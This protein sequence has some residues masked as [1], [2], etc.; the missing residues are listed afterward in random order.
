MPFVF[1]ATIADNLRFA[2]PDAT[3]DQLRAALAAVQ[4]TEFV[5]ELPDGVDAVIGE[6][7]VSLSGG[8]RQ[9]LALA[10]AALARPSVLLIDGGTSALDT[11][12]EIAVVAGIRH[13][14][15]DSAVVLV[16]TNQAVA[17]TASQ[18]VELGD[19][20][21]VTRAEPHEQ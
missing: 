14:L 20:Q 5:A 9:R 7:G 6:R 16:T 12:T 10:R 4:A 8:Q 2:A 11:D 15:A 17:A 18:V 3:D 13:A 1:A 21:L 19:G